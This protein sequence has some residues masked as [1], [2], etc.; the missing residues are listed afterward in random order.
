MPILYIYGTSVELSSGKGRSIV[1]RV[2][3]AA[4]LG[5]TE[6]TISVMT[7]KGVITPC[8][9]RLGRIPMFFEE[10]IEELKEKRE[11]EHY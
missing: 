1:T 11:K 6:R 4:R 8:P 9:E 7:Q 3:A 5:L 10:E 2:Q